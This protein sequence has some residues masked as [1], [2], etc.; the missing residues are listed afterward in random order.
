MPKCVT[1]TT[2]VDSKSLTELTERVAAVELE[3]NEL[4]AAEEANLTCC[5]PVDEAIIGFTANSGLPGTEQTEMAAVFASFAPDFVFLGGGNVY[6]GDTIDNNLSWIQGRIDDEDVW[7]AWGVSDWTDF[8]LTDVIAKFPYIPS[9]L[10]SQRYY[11]KMMPKGNLE[12]FVII[13]DPA[14]PDGIVLGSTQYTKLNAAIT[15]STAKR[16]VAMVYHPPFSPVSG[17]VDGTDFDADFL[18]WY[19][20]LKQCDLILT[21]QNIASWVANWNGTTVVNAGSSTGVLATLAPTV[22]IGTA[23]GPGLIWS[24]ATNRHFVKLISGNHGLRVEFIRFGGVLGSD[25]LI[26]FSITIP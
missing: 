17:K 12:L 18:D 26:D 21:G 5:D 8:T 1:P 14:E 15:D 16:K 7:P 22:G 2:V 24:D 19:P 3:V 23:G 6:A 10:G 13:S 9:T 4:Q 20:I 11:H 25:T